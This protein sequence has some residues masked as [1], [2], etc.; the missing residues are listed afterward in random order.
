MK[1]HT[2]PPYLDIKRD[3]TICSPLCIAFKSHLP[4]S[5][6]EAGTILHLVNSHVNLYTIN[7]CAHTGI[8]F[9]F[10]VFK[11]I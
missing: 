8:Q 3:K 2:P 1:I 7:A 11:L 6:R 4:L 5:T 10:A 9:S